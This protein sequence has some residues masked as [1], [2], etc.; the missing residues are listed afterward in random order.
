MPSRYAPALYFLPASSGCLWGCSYVDVNLCELG[1]SGWLRVVEESD[2]Q[3]EEVGGQA[4]GRAARGGG[5]GQTYLMGALGHSS[6]SVK[7]IRSKCSAKQC[8]KSVFTVTRRLIWQ[9]FRAGIRLWG[10]GVSS[11]GSF[12]ESNV[13]W[14]GKSE[15]SC[16]IRESSVPPFLCF[17]YNRKSMCW[18]EG[19]L[20]HLP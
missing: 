20:S 11:Q 15:S 19:G 17:Y 13:E 12:L 3:M 5:G 7:S 2:D 9:V 16:C 6:P 14:R 4:G 8:Q 10:K 18:S 1:A